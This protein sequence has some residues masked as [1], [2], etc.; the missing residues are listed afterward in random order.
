MSDA[1]MH[2]NRYNLDSDLSLIGS[3]I[4]ILRLMVEQPDFDWPA[5]PI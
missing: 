1:S 5:Q 2:L 3:P 4:R